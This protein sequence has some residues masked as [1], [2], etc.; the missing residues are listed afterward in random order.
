MAGEAYLE[1]PARQAL[2]DSAQPT[3]CSSEDGR[4]VV[5]VDNV[6]S[7]Y[8]Q[9]LKSAA[10]RPSAICKFH[11]FIGLT[12]PIESG[13]KLCS[14]TVTSDRSCTLRRRPACATQ[15]ENPDALSRC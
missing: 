6:N 8:D 12:S 3:P 9:A 11:P 5:G 4:A 15:L 1:S 2:S 14:K 10:R 7:Y 13:P